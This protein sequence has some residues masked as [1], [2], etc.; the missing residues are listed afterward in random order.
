MFG[1]PAV[2]EDVQ[3]LQPHIAVDGSFEAGGEL[4]ECNGIL[5]HKP[6]V[7]LRLR[8]SRAL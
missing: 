4:R 6:N 1:N 7:V 2:K 8:M 5:F 3:P